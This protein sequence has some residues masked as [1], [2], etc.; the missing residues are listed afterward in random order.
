MGYQING[1]DVTSVIACNSN[2]LS[3]LDS[4][5]S[6]KNFSNVFKNFG[7]NFAQK[8]SDIGWGKEYL[9]FPYKMI[10]ANGND[11]TPKFLTAESCPYQKR[12]LGSLVSSWGDVSLG[13]GSYTMHYEN[14]YIYIKSGS[15]TLYSKKRS[16]KLVFIDI[17][18]GG[19]GGGYMHWGTLDNCPGGGGGGGASA[20]VAVNLSKSI[21]ISVGSAGSQDGGNGGSSTISDGSNTIV[22]G[23]GTGG[24]NGN[25]GKRGGDGGKCSGSL[26]QNN[27]F[28][29]SDVFLKAVGYHGKGGG[30]GK[31]GNNSNSLTRNPGGSFKPTDKE[32]D[33]IPNFGVIADQKI[34]ISKDGTHNS[35]VGR[36]DQEYTY[37]ST[38]KMFL[39]G[40]GGACAMGW[41]GM[42]NGSGSSGG[43][44]TGGYW[45]K[46]TNLQREHGGAGGEGRCV[47][48]W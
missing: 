47:I 27:Q 24:E 45:I 5:N 7:S 4:T 30:D 46:E 48:H 2:F 17:C 34:G 22:C 32:N 20:F 13:S 16:N 42:A 18:G 37:S 11:I 33:V 36:G 44:G 10:D 29:T 41:C 15:T 38:E 21:S 3:K 23:G 39:G 43:G 14:G 9:N 8:I 25:K 12:S 40:G 26:W 6:F 31:E 28:N 35:W 19:G 1:E